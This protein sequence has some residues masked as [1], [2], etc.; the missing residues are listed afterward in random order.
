MIDINSKIRAFPT[1]LKNVEMYKYN[2]ELNIY[3][4]C[5]SKE[6]LFNDFQS[7]KYNL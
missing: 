6:N 4:I 7:P 2:I 5:A 3:Y 1:K